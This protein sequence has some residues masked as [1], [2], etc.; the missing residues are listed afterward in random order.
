MVTWPESR[1]PLYAAT[2]TVQQEPPCSCPGRLAAH[3]VTVL[4]CDLL[5]EDTALE[6][7]GKIEK[8]IHL[9]SLLVEVRVCCGNLDQ[10]QP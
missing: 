9:S 2:R 8:L 7:T 6:N 3:R 1:R 5:S 4:L 10:N